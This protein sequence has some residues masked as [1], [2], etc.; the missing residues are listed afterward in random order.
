M[1]RRHDVNDINLSIY[2]IEPIKNGLCIYWDSSIGFGE[3]NIWVEEDGRICGDSE[4]MDSQDDKDFIRKL[5]ELIADQM[6]I[7]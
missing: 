2:K 6:T 5:L 7:Y 4:C 3:Y 1:S